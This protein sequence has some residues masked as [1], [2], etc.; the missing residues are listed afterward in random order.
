VDGRNRAIVRA[1]SRSLEIGR[2]PVRMRIIDVGQNNNAIEMRIDYE[3]AEAPAKAYYSDYCDVIHGRGGVSL[4]FGKVNPGTSQLRSKI[5][6]VFPEEMFVRQ[7]WKNTRHLEPVVKHEFQKR[8]LEPIAAAQ[9]NLDVAQ[10]FRS[11]NVFL[12]VMAEE[13]LMDFYYIAPTEVHYAF[14]RKRTEIQLDPVLRVVL[15]SSLVF[16][17]LEKAKPIV[18][19][20]PDF[21][22]IMREE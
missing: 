13:A 21:E 16:E 7:L 20:L 12:I 4:I 3:K 17:L 5:E 10:S 8:P 14:T 22:S 9:P 15:P 19:R 1:E 6:V 2:G 18:E 11:N